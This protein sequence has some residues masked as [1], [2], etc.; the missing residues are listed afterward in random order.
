MAYNSYRGSWKD[1]EL[2]KKYAENTDIH[3]YAFD[4]GEA[5]S[6]PCAGRK[7]HFDFTSVDSKFDN[8]VKCDPKARFHLR[9]NLERNDQWWQ[10]LYPQE[11]EI[12]SLGI[13][14][15]QSF[16][17]KIWRDQS[18]DFL[19]TFVEHIKDIGMASRAI[20]YQVGAG[21]TGEWCKRNSS[22]ANPCGD[23]SEPM[24]RHF[25]EWLRNKYY[26]DV[27]TLRRAWNNNTITY[28]TVEVPSEK[29]QLNALNYSF[30]NP[31]LEQNIIDYFQCLAELCADLIIDFCHTTKSATENM[32]MAGA[33]YGYILEMS[34]NSCFFAEWN[35]RWQEGD[36]G[37]LQR[38]GHLGLRKVL[39][40]PDVDFLVS[41]YCYGFRGV[42]GDGPC[43]QPS[44][45]L[46]LHGKLY[47]YEEDSRLHTEPPNANYGRASDLNQS[48]AILR[49]NF[50]YIATHGHGF[51]T[52]LH[53]DENIF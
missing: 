25:C 6:G 43:M 14:Y 20:A 18:K 30:R 50:S 17:S 48:L 21:H 8:I 5:W 29:Q 16:A 22:M 12:T 36:Y 41:P 52:F 3:I 15:Q 44:E 35:E 33:F 24:R 39:E 28:N 4:V 19:R 45:S 40:S 38:S 9:I 27:S 47:I 23:Y 10:E 34:W 49:R 37:T 26:N 13:Q 32:S 51:W 1:T 31:S 11:C 42:G 7:G 2:L 53:S 46:R